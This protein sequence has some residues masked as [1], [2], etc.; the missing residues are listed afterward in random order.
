M[1]VESISNTEHL[2]EAAYTV[3]KEKGFDVK[4]NS[5][6]VDFLSKNN[7]NFK[8]H[9][10]SKILY[11][12]DFDFF[13]DTNIYNYVVDNQGTYE[14]FTFPVKRFTSSFALENLVISINNNVTTIYLVRYDFDD[15][16]M[17]QFKSGIEVLGD[18]HFE[19]IELNGFTEADLF[20]KVEFNEDTQCWEDVVTYHSNPY[21][22]Y[23]Y[24]GYCPHEE[25]YCTVHT[26]VSQLYCHGG[27]SGNGGT[28]GTGDGGSGGSGGGSSGSDSGSDGDDLGDL[29]CKGCDDDPDFVITEPIIDDSI[30]LS[31]CE[32]I[33]NTMSKS[34]ANHSSR[35]ADVNLLLNDLSNAVNA[36]T[37]EMSYVLTPLTTA[38][39]SFQANYTE[40]VAGE[41]EVI[42]QLNTINTAIS[43]LMHIH[44]NT[45]TPAPGKKQLSV[46]SLNDIYTIYKFVMT[47]N[48]F[49][50]NTF[51][52]TLSTEHGTHYVLTINDGDSFKNSEYAQKYFAHWE[53]TNPDFLMSN[54]KAVYEFTYTYGISVDKPIA[55]VEEQFVKFLSNKELALTLYRSNSTFTE[56][57]QLDYEDGNLIE[58]PC[59]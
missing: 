58:T 33:K 52:S 54:K 6:V 7:L 12:D 55:G 40:G 27:G 30:S 36:A 13:V 29:G 11:F 28:G 43:I 53:D 48:I 42:V 24:E 37:G 5:A 18:F 22:T 45:E 20:N 34:I 49:S 3:R 50:P 14:S 56:F 23:V 38:E 51:M 2:I 47:G 26:M 57:T 8:N 25:G 16:Q 21:G 44:Y 10:A 32:Q 9:E 19:F 46:F 4:H 39:D 59:E 17:L 1:D 41:D 15:A 35:T 31:D